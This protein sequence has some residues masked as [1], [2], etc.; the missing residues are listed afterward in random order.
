LDKKCKRD[1][2]ASMNRLSNRQPGNDMLH[3]DHRIAIPV[4]AACRFNEGSHARL[5]GHDPKSAQASDQ[6]VVANSS[7]R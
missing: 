5:N 6:A 7:E 1:W 4:F 3:A 2:F